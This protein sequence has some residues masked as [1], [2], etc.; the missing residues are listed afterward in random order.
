MG[1][2]DRDREMSSVGVKARKERCQPG[3]GLSSFM[4]INKHVSIVVPSGRDLQ[5]LPELKSLSHPLSCAS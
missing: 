2:G 1:A 4:V 5:A 3:A